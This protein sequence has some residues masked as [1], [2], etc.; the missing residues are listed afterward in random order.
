MFK[1]TLLKLNTGLYVPLNASTVAWNAGVTNDAYGNPTMPITASFGIEYTTEPQYTFASTCYGIGENE[2]KQVNVIDPMGAAHSLPSSFIYDDDGCVLPPASAVTTDGSGLTVV[3]HSSSQPYNWTIYDKSGNSYTQSLAAYGFSWAHSYTM[4]DPHGS[5]NQ[6][7]RTFNT[8]TKTW[9]WT[10]V[11]GSVVLTESHDLGAGNTPLDKYVYHD[12]SGNPQTY[13]VDYTNYTIGTNYQCTNIAELG[14]S[15]YFP[16]TVKIPGG[17]SYSLSWE[18]QSKSVAK[19][20]GHLAQVTSPNGSYVAYTYTGGNNGESCSTGVVPTLT[21]TSSPDGTSTSSVTYVNNQGPNNFTVTATNSVDNSEIVDSYTTLDNNVFSGVVWPNPGIFHTSSV[22]YQGSTQLSS[23]ITCTNGV[24]SGGPSACV[25]PS[26]YP[27]YPTSSIDT[28]SNMAPMAAGNTNHI[29]STFNTTYGLPLA[30]T[31]YDWGTSWGG[32]LLS[33][34][35][36]A[37]GSGSSCTTIGS[38]INDRPCYRQVTSGTSTFRLTYFIYNPQGDLTGTQQEVEANGTWLNYTIGRNANGTASSITQTSNSGMGSTTFTYGDCNGFR[39]TK[40]AFNVATAGSIQKSWDC[41]GGVPASVTDQNGNTI[42]YKYVDPLYRPTLVQYPDSTSDT[43][44]FSYSAN[45]TFPP[46]ATLTSALTASTNIQTTTTFDGFGRV[47]ATTTNDPNS[48]TGYRYTNRIYNGLGQLITASNPY[49][50]NGT[51]CMPA[52]NTY[53]VTQ[54]QYDALGRITQLIN[55]DSSVI[56]TYFSGNDTHVYGLWSLNTYSQ[57]D[58]AGRTTIS[59][60]GIGA[61]TQANGDSTTPCGLGYYSVN[62]FPTT[63]FYNPAG[64]LT[65]T[66]MSG[67]STSETK[68]FTPDMAGRITQQTLPES[69]TEYFT[70]DSPIV[71][72]LSTHKDARGII[73]TY[74]V[75]AIYRPTKVSF[76][77]STPT[78]TNIYDVGTGSGLIGRLASA[79]TPNTV[80]WFNY[81]SMGHMFLKTVET[82]LEFGTRGSN[83]QYGFDFMAT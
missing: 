50:C 40:M 2:Y 5:T 9:T 44:T 46:T 6:V 4:Q 74:T 63:Y 8:T 11:T 16:T 69:G 77:D 47:T 57:T 23:T 48:P 26:S 18:N 30:T 73:T 75:D 54:Y 68:S 64:D 58:G 81:D 36:T 35:V 45:T 14:G 12:S 71:G 49:F 59:C 80:T 24:P 39:L 65:S 82:P 78:I 15:A 25:A 13:E 31:V 61:G 7:T 32:S 19:K 20:T 34:T 17:G 27:Q 76:S 22:V 62:G 79:N 70:Y 66:T 56:N 83:I 42:T 37:Y 38:Y 29:N 53:G 72:Q 67:S 21:V 33:K 55:P 28:Y 1:G 41:N 43:D 52:D 60:A 10:D 3:T 51:N